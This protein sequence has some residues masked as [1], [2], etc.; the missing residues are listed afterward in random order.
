VQ[1]DGERLPFASAAFD[2]IFSDHGALSFCEPDVAVAECAR[3][4][5]PGGALVFCCTHP[6]L[7]LTWDA[8]QGRQTRKLRVDYA[9]LG[10]TTPSEGT[11]DWALPPSGWIRVLR[12]NGFEIEDLIELCARTDAATTFAEF[13]P[14][15][16]ARRW[17]AEWIWK[18][19]RRP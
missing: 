4:L 12:A 8:A 6:L 19:R 2:V 9:Q 11:I 15:K 10:R 7:Y 13:A 16:W 17:P 14:P 5:R 1:G 18:A 3:L